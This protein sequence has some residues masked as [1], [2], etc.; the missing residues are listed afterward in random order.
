MA[1]AAKARSKVVSIEG[2]PRRARTGAQPALEPALSPGLHV[3]SI[4]LQASASFRVRAAGGEVVSA[5]LA[6]GFDRD[7]AEECLR[8]HRPVLA[9]VSADGRVLLVGALQTRRQV[10]RD[11]Q[12][13]LHLEGKRVEIRATDEARIHVG[14]STL[15]LDSK[16][17]IRFTGQKMTMDVATVVR[18]LSSLVELP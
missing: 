11:G 9:Q 3:V 2:R 18:V 13:A 4:E 1:R 5:A 12:G 16:G 10:E 8:D 6:D 7:F 17:A 14:K 15:R